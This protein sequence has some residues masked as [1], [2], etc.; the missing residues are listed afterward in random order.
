MFLIAVEWLLKFAITK[1]SSHLVHVE[2]VYLVHFHCSH[3]I[4]EIEMSVCWKMLKGKT[5]TKMKENCL[6]GKNVYAMKQFPST[7]YGIVIV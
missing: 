1:A 5:K 6:F 3:L 7:N 4:V 2:K